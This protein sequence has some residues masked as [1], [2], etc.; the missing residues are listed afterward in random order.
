MEIVKGPIGS[1]GQYEVKISGGKFVVE[2]GYVHGAFGGGANFSI[3]LE[4]IK[5]AFKKVIPGGVD[6]AIIDVMFATL[7]SI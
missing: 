1:G 6:D 3:D 4:V 5:D 2:S 7:K